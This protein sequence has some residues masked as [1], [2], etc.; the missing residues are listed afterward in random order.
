MIYS[1]S[2]SHPLWLPLL[3]RVTHS[4]L[5]PVVAV[6]QLSFL[7]TGHRRRNET[8]TVG[9]VCRTYSVAIR[10]PGV[11]VGARWTASVTSNDGTLYAVDGQSGDQRWAFTEPG[12]WVA[13]SPT[14]VTD[15]ESGDSVGSRVQQELLGHHDE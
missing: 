15:P 3:R 2:V 7:Q 5:L 8:V 1:L 10:I 4:N 6:Q 13:S 9:A 14:V 11:V 12:G